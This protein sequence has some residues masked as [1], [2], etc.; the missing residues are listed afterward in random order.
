MDVLAHGAL[1]LGG[2]VAA[3]ALLG[4]VVRTY[5]LPASAEFPRWVSAWLV[6]TSVIVIWDASFVLSRPASFA[7]ILWAPYRDYIVVDTLY[8]NVQDSFVWSQ[9]ILNLVEVFLNVVSLS[10]LGAN[11]HRAAAVVAIFVC[12][13]TSSKTLLY[14]VMEAA[15][16]YS[17][18][19]HNDPMTLLMLY[20]LPNGV[21]LIVPA[22]CAA[23]L[24]VRLA[25]CGQVKR[26]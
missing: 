9:S 19:R 4:Y 23:S 5:L 3:M 17:H 14:F 20:I 18:V 26:D 7:H 10:L 15:C 1:L 22:F 11:R 24:G 16:G 8:G 6:I 12:A 21:W 2:L 25:G 13:M